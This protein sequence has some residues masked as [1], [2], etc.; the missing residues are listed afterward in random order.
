MSTRAIIQSKMGFQMW[1]FYIHPFSLSKSQMLDASQLRPFLYVQTCYPYHP[2][3]EDGKAADQRVHFSAGIVASIILFPFAAR[4]SSPSVHIPFDRV[5]SS[6][7]CP[8]NATPFCIETKAYQRHIT[9]ARGE[10]SSAG[11]PF[12]QSAI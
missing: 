6:Q 12:N 1:H 4:L 3:H 7:Q 9:F 8:Q 5:P 10:A 2:P 11:P